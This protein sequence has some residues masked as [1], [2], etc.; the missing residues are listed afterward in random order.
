MLSTTT[1]PL[2]TYFYTRVVSVTGFDSTP[3]RF[4]ND[5]Y[6]RS[7]GYINGS[8]GISRGV[9]LSAESR[10][11]RDLTVFGSYTYARANTDLDLTVRGFFQ[12]LNVP[13]QT[14]SFVATQHIGR[15]LGVTLDLTGNGEYPYPFF[16]GTRTA[17]FRFP[18]FVKTDLSTSFAIKE[19]DAYT[20]K[21]FRF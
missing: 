18:G 13:R 8:G 19:T 1:V 12:V 11:T 15:R 14:F 9:E 16:A 6:G 17:A 2:G 3:S 21:A 20:V 4:L 5:P 10:P 7:F